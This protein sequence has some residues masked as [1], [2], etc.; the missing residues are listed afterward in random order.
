MGRP[1]ACAIALPNL[2][3][4]SMGGEKLLRTP[5]CGKR[6]GTGCGQLAGSLTAPG[7]AS[8]CAKLRPASASQPLGLRCFLPVVFPTLGMMVSYDGQSGA[9]APAAGTLLWAEEG[10]GAYAHSNPSPTTKTQTLTVI[11]TLTLTSH[12]SPSPR[13]VRALY[14]R[15]ARH[16][17]A[18]ARRPL[19]HR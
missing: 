12:L 8:G 7:R 19:P 15:R 11:L 13:R 6:G 10:I 3:R 17:R 9:V 18:R 14:W 4:N 16:G 2:P 5:A 1:V